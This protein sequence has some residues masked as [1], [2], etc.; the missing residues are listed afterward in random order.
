MRKI[1][2]IFVL[3]FV[4]VIIFVSGTACQ[5]SG[6]SDKLAVAVS[7]VPEA[8][9]VKAVAG[10]LL[11]VVTMIPPGNSPANYSPSPKELTKFSDSGIYF[12]MGVPADM[13]NIL[14]KAEEINPD[15]KVVK[16]FAELN[17]VYPD[18]EFSPGKRD[19]HIWLSPKRAKI[20]VRI[21]ARE[22]A[23]IDEKNRDVYQKNAGEYINKLNELDQEIS[24]SLSKL[25]NKTFIVYH[26]AF[27][28][29]ADDYGL[30]ML[31]IEEEGKEATPR[32]VQK[33]IDLA[34]KENIKAIFYQ[35]E[36]DS[37]QSQAIAEEIGGK[38]IQVDPLA[39][40]YIKN[41]QKTAE[42]FND[43]LN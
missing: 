20:M 3:L 38:T 34:K 2:R 13:T 39:A 26:P 24:N 25:K 5:V 40:D 29:F 42:V 30:E 18:R 16:L 19:P 36:I 14:A 37:R 43:I 12:A 35:A 10:E 33:I 23:E 6:E 8:T 7:I 9:F 31:A 41:L 4:V 17:E 21:I 27:G 28:Y 32:R 15:I 11:D 1:A 22:L